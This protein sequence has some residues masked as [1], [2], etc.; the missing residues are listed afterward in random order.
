MADSTPRGYFP[1]EL[2]PSA[3]F[4]QAFRYASAAWRDRSSLAI[5]LFVALS[6]A[7]ACLAWFLFRNDLVATRGQAFHP[8]SLS[9]VSAF[10]VL[11][12]TL[13]FLIG[14]IVS[15]R[16]YRSI[17]GVLDPPP[18]LGTVTRSA[19]V[20]APILGLISLL[21]ILV[22]RFGLTIEG[23]S[24]LLPGHHLI[25]GF[26][27][28]DWVTLLLWL[29]V[30]P[31]FKFAPAVLAIEGRSVLGSLGRSVRLVQEGRGRP[32]ALNILIIAFLTVVGG[33]IAFLL[34]PLLRDPVLVGVQVGWG[35][36]AIESPTFFALTTGWILVRA[37]WVTQV[38][39]AWCLSYLEVRT[40]RE[41][42]DVEFDGRIAELLPTDKESR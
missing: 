24:S 35:A 3:C 29:G 40:R 37:L 1:R 8:L 39:G 2:S 19:L 20:M 18:A 17:H 23:R 13:E 12:V 15:N 33:G 42:L 21:P 32:H 10:H 34:R 11:I 6:F 41:G 26:Q 38:Q 27:P 14:V 30:V 9:T 5:V 28:E 7:E 16:V 22:V 4:D 36:L 31:F 25:S